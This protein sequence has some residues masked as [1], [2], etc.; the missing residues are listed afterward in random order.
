MIGQ[1]KFAVVI[2]MLFGGA[3]GAWW[4]GLADYR[5]TMSEL[6]TLKSEFNDQ[7]KEMEKMRLHVEETEKV[8]KAVDSLKAAIQNERR[9]TDEKLEDSRCYIGVERLDRLERL[10]EDDLARRGTCGASGDSAQGLRGAKGSGPGDN[11][12][13]SG[14]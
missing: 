11:G 1:A 12:L 3:L 13:P 2:V 7:K 6:A 9:A 8:L 10:L 14:K 5:G 4:W